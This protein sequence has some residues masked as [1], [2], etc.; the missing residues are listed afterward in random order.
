MSPPVTRKGR[1]PLGRSRAGAPLQ[2][3]PSTRALRQ[4]R[5]RL[6][7]SRRS[8]RAL[9]L[10]SP[11][12]RRRNAGAR[13]QPD[14]ASHFEWESRK[15]ILWRRAMLPATVPA[16]IELAGFGNALNSPHLCCGLD[17]ASEGVSTVSMC[18]PSRCRS[19]APLPPGDRMT[20]ANTVLPVSVSAL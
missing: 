1:W 5:R 8:R 9:G 4:H 16:Q 10:A 7:S 20:P 18:L 17:A 13:W 19:A 3:R 11:P 14:G 12:R 6:A 2:I 15:L